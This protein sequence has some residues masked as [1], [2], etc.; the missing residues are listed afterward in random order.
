MKTEIEGNYQIEM[1]K[2]F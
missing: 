1:K 2:P